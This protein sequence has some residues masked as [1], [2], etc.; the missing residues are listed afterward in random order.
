MRSASA[1]LALVF[2]AAVLTSVGRA[3]Q[4]SIGVLHVQGNV[5]L[6]ATVAGNVA[7]QVGPE[8]V[9]LVDTSAAA[10]TAE[11]LAAVRTL[12]DKP[13]RW[14][15]NTHAH[16]DHTGGNEAMS[17]AGSGTPQNRF[18]S[19]LAFPGSLPSGAVIVAHESVLH[20][21]STPSG[22]KPP[23]PQG[24]W[25]VAAYIGDGRELFFNGEAIQIYHAPRAHTD[26]DTLV[27]FRH[28]DVIATGD[29]F[30]TNSFPVIDVETGGT[31]DGVIAGLNHVLDIAI[32]AEKQEGGTS[33]IPGHG[34]LGDE[35]DVVQYRNM[36]TIVRDR[37]QDMLKRGMTLD[38]VK[39]AK[40]TA[41]YDRRWSTPAWTA[42][43]FVDGVYR[44][45]GPAPATAQR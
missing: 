25:P 23:A 12:S 28:S 45:L 40:P 44:S 30:N 27:Y 42:D 34:R 13:V 22:G 36:V 41:G 16:G 2:A 5:H 19:G 7:V 20:R 3:Q 39:Q 11:L 29:V 38:Q 8:G 15:V 37:V 10:V 17:K 4:P 21:M 6:L 24:A 14:I 31:I 32:P 35:A 33:V 43:M 1:V 26:G 9:L 18:G